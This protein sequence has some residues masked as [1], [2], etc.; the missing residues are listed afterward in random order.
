MSF[1]FFMVAAPV[2]SLF[3]VAGEVCKRPCSQQFRIPPL[4]QAVDG[5]ANT[6]HIVKIPEGIAAIIALEAKEC[7]PP[8]SPTAFRRPKRNLYITGADTAR[9][10]TAWR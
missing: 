3:P 10:T 8:P 2:S 6:E 5:L 9:L 4:H 1:L 7:A